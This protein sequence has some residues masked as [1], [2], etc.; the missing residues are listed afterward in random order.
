MVVGQAVALLLWDVL[1]LGASFA[2]GLLEAA[3]PVKIQQDSQLG[4]SGGSGKPL[5]GLSSILASR[6]DASL[7]VELLVFGAL[8]TGLV[9]TQLLRALHAPANSPVKP[10]KEHAQGV[11]VAAD[12]SR[13]ALAAGRKQQKG[14]K[15][16][17]GVRRR[18]GTRL[19]TVALLVAVLCLVLAAAVRP[20]LWVLGFALGS[21]RRVALLGY[22]GL[23]LAGAL[24]FM[25]WVSGRV[26]TI[27][28]RK[29]LCS[30]PNA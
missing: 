1:L 14:V 13:E 26:P 10:D 19:G 7:F 12:G 24:P 23:L 11:S 5:G 3:L 6:S 22:W 8:L 2:A 20:A 18:E 15:R 30:H 28:V 9:V 25:D 17:E 4:G 21:W 27:I 16:R 29:V